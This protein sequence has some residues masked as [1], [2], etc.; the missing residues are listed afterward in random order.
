ME[1]LL[2]QLFAGKIKSRQLEDLTDA[3][4]AR[5]V[6]LSFLAAETRSELEDFANIGF[7]AESVKNKN[8]E[9]LIGSVEVP[10][11]IAGPLLV[12]GQ[13]ANGS[14]YIPMA[15][16]EGAL[17]ASTARGCKAITAAK[18]AMVTQ[19]LK[20]ISRA[21]LF[22]LTSAR[23]ASSLKKWIAGNMRNLNSLI[24]ESSRHIK[25]L[26]VSY[27]Q[28]G[29]YLWIRFNFDT[30]EA[31]GMNMAT[32]AS[33]AISQKIC[34]HFRKVKLISL[35]GNVCVD[36]KPS[37]LNLLLGRGRE[38]IA[39]VFLPGKVISQVL[40]TTAEAI[41]RVNRT[42]TWY[43]SAMAGS[44]SFNAHFA[45]IIAAVFVATGQ[46]LAHIVDSSQGFCIMEAEKDG[47][48][49]SVSLPSLLMG[50]IGG[51]TSL[52]KQ[53]AAKNMMVKAVSN[54]KAKTSKNQTSVLADITAAAVLA[55]ELSLHAALAADELVTAHETLGKGKL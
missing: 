40:N 37:E 15:T 47:L 22:L 13:H 55:G 46:D 32:R 23:D 5:K 38:L 34:E 48:Y 11:G 49:A 45:N 27:F 8:I 18:G 53:L 39:E 44:L 33:L 41:A 28:N 42:K 2:K 21:P 50:F 7:E 10:L 12:N 1:D 29:R 6:R 43:G 51:G 16:T 26:Q 31:M 20:G 30:D 9:N 19:N 4:T 35:S 36:K 52:P 17:I 14:Y 3:E 54:K 24:S 25:L